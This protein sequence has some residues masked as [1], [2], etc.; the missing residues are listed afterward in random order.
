MQRIHADALDVRRVP[1]ERNSL[2]QRIAR[3]ARRGAACS[4]GAIERSR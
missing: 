2:S 3:R 1:P 4:V